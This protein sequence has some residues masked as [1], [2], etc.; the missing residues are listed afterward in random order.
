MKEAY[1]YKKLKGKGVRCRNCAHY[2][3]I[4]PGKRGICGVRE[5]INGK[6]YALNYG[7]AVA[8]NID[9]IEKKPFFHFLPGSHSLS[10]ATV[11]CNFRCLNCQ[12]SDISQGFKWAK[13]IPGE[14]LPPKKIVDLAIKN[15][16]P[17]IS[18]TYT[19]PT[20]FLEYAIDTMKLAKKAGLKNNFVSNGF[21]SPE[22]AKL[23]IPHLDANNIDIK[24]FTEE[25][26]GE[27]CGA[28]LQPVLKTAKLMKKSGVWVEITTLAIPGRSDSEKMFRGIAKFIYEELGSETPWHISQFSGAI[29]WKLQ[30]IPDTPV[31]TLEVGYK[32]GKE[33]GLKYVYTGNIP[34]LPSE[35]TFCPKCGALSIDRTNYIIHRHDKTGKCSR[36]GED[37]NLILNPV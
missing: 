16:L 24:G 22:S 13:E 15:N 10:I 33:I 2:C 36:C 27:N 23:V 37:L 25:F 26:Y 5:N 31:E 17:S 9:P 32:I 1:L 14:D 34:G 4:S 20:I 8:V 3:V 28:Q 6:L 12:N 7:K 29:S 30:H 35:D 18:Y 19:E 21:M 11:G